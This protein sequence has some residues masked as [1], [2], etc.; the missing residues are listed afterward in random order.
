MTDVD[1][2]AYVSELEWNREDNIDLRLK[3]PNWRG[4]DCKINYIQ[5]IF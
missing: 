4:L 3:F 2:R 5:P 1:K